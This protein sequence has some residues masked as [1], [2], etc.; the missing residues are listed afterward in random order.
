MICV[1]A[2][3]KSTLDRMLD[4]IPDTCIRLFFAL[5]TLNSLKD[6]PEQCTPRSQYRSGLTL[7]TIVSGIQQDF[8]IYVTISQINFM[9]S[10]INRVI[11]SKYLKQLWYS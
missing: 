2:L 10:G 7:G 8:C 5:F 9:M 1:Y 3:A 6:K 11:V 4:R